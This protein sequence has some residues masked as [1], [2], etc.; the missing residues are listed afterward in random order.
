MALFQAQVM[1]SLIRRRHRAL[2]IP[3]F[4]FFP[5]VVDTCVYLI[6]PDDVLKT[7]LQKLL[8]LFCCRHSDAYIRC[9][10]RCDDAFCAGARFNAFFFKYRVGFIA[11]TSAREF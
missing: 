1:S 10:E 3:F 11:L 5:V 7:L 4:F 6:P 2:F 8:L 9:W